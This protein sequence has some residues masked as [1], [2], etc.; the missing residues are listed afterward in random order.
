MRKL[1]LIFILVIISIG[2]ISQSRLKRGMRVG[3]SGNEITIDSILNE[4]GFLTLYF[5]GIAY[6]AS[7]PDSVS[8]SE[9]VS[10]TDIV[11]IRAGG[12][13]YAI[14]KGLL[15]SEQST[16]ITSLNTTIS[17]LQTR[18]AALELES[19]FDS[20]V[21]SSDLDTIYAYYTAPTGQVKIPW[22]TLGNQDVEKPTVSSMLIDDPDDDIIIITMS[23]RMMDSI[24]D[25]TGGGGTGLFPDITAAY[26]F[27]ELSGITLYDR[28]GST[29]GVND[30]ALVFDSA[31]IALYGYYFDGT[32]TVNITTGHSYGTND[33]S[34]SVWIKPHSLSSDFRILSGATGGMLVGYQAAGTG[35]WMGIVG[36]S[37][38]TPTT[39]NLNINAWNHV[40]WSYDQTAN[41]VTWWINASTE[42]AAAFTQ[43]F[44][45]ATNMIGGS[46]YGSYFVGVMDDLFL[47]NGTKMA[48]ARVDS[49]YFAGVG[50]RYNESGTAGSANQDSI[51]N[52]FTVSFS[53]PLVPVNVDS[54]IINNQQIRL[55]LDASAI[56]SNTVRVSYDKPVTFALRDTAD[57]YADSW[58]LYNVTN[59]VDTTTVDNNVFIVTRKD[60]TGLTLGD[61]TAAAMESYYGGTIYGHTTGDN[62]DA[63]VTQTLN[64]ALDT[65]LRA[66]NAPYVDPI[67]GSGGTEITFGM[68][69]TMR[70][71]FL[72][73][74][75]KLASDYRL[76]GGHAKMA[77]FRTLKQVSSSWPMDANVNGWVG[78]ILVKEGGFFDTYHYDYTNWVNYNPWALGW[79][80]QGG[81]DYDTDFLTY[82]SWHKVDIRI[83]MN[84]WTAGVANWD[85]VYEVA[86]DNNIVYQA[87]GMRLHT[88]DSPINLIQSIWI[89]TFQNYRVTE[90]F[91]VYFDEF[92][93]YIPLN[94]AYLGQNVVHPT[95]WD[96]PLVVPTDDLYSDSTITLASEDVTMVSS[97]G[98]ENYRWIIDAGVGNKVTLSWNSGDVPSGAYVIT[99][100]GKKAGGDII[101]KYEGNINPMSTQVNSVSAGRYMYIYLVSGSGGGIDL[102]GNITFSAQ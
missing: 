22:A 23:D 5:E 67:W 49:L 38:S 85:G 34:G 12:E 31:G 70:E 98:W 62:R 102:S 15:M 48:Q 18:V 20:I 2:A 11:L 9:A 16:R 7:N 57:N 30:G 1:F 81:S 90:T 45:A 37:L 8:V 24:T 66:T 63:I 27:D 100:E 92:I 68:D 21:V 75:V 65:C 94:D 19:V 55:F 54:V 58:L 14:S 72:T 42:A 6:E 40:C 36:G 77:G 35:L 44:T 61:K 43:E 10:N 89:A 84:T 51:K 3:K 46:G 41:E 82:G 39:M 26:N 91:Y 73:Y 56:H 95:M 74:Y 88:I 78:S 64:G 52:A 60:Y 29:P 96:S 50:R 86:L 32:A 4:N 53:T 101:H 17:V 28:V 99:Y 69:T 80:I 59:S 71:A 93:C 87:N 47:W 33:L 76:E 79:S 83:K 97:S 13:T 25:I